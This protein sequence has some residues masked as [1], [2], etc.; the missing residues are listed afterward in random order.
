M[1]GVNVPSAGPMNAAAEYVPIARP[2]C[3]AGNKSEIVPPELPKG[4]EPKKPARNRRTIKVQMFCEPAAPALNAVMQIKVQMK[5]TRRPDVSLSGAQT[6]GPKANPRTNTEIPRRTISR[7]TS[8]AVMICCK[9]PAYADEDTE[10]DSVISAIMKVNHHFVRLLKFIGLRRSPGIHDT[11]YGS[12][13]VPEPSYGKSIIS[14]V[15]TFWSNIMRQY[16][17]LDDPRAILGLDSVAM[18]VAMVLERKCQI[19]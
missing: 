13:F 11:T 7:S 15:T 10:A 6:N 8:N 18:V 9:L 12:S 14:S 3:E 16:G 1:D 17:I 2:R 4:D 5:I 19:P